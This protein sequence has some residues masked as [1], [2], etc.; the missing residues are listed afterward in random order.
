MAS[1]VFET[2]C[3]FRVSDLS[4][5]A[6][7]VDDESILIFEPWR[8]DVFFSI[9]GGGGG[10]IRRR[11]GDSSTFVVRGLETVYD[12]WAA[13]NAFCDDIERV[14]L[15]F[16]VV[17][18]KGTSVCKVVVDV[19]AE[20]RFREVVGDADFVRRDGNGWIG[21]RREDGSI[22]RWRLGTDEVG[23]FGCKS[24]VQAL[25][26]IIEACDLARAVVDDASFEERT[27]TTPMKKTRKRRRDDDETDARGG[28]RRSRAKETSVDA[29]ENANDRRNVKK[30]SR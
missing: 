9:G 2:V 5:A 29:S 15:D 16:E 14:P 28:E 22:V 26:A 24:I 7:L 1:T 21:R 11:D 18:V 12:A 10:T 19:D 8:R 13:A 3:S 27:T 25:V 17:E 6:A 4:D 30:K 20:S 23:V